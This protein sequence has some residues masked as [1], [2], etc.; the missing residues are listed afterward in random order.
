M[1]FGHAPRFERL[2]DGTFYARAGGQTNCAGVAGI[3]VRMTAN[4][5]PGLTF[6]VAGEAGDEVDAYGPAVPGFAV[7][8]PFRDAI[9]RRAGSPRRVR[10]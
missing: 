3:H 1:F 4:A 5:A 6:G 7:L 8:A 10:W 2:P 9:A